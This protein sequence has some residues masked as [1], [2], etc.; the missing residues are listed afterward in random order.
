VVDGELGAPAETSAC[1]D[2]AQVVAELVEPAEIV[3]IVEPA[4]P[5]VA[6]GTANDLRAW[7]Q[8]DRRTVVAELMREHGDVVF[9]FCL[10]L[11]RVRALA[12]DLLQQVFLQA[13]RDLDQF[14][15]RSSPRA[16]LIGIAS[17]RCLDALRAQQRRST[18]IDDDQ[19]IFALEDRAPGPDERVDRMRLS[20][21][22]E[23]CLQR[24]SA[25]LRATVLLRFQTGAT[26]EELAVSLAATADTLQMRVARALPILRRCLEQKGWTGD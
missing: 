5:E 6:A 9:G 13:Y 23:G 20:A 4:V 7:S 12:D 17:H 1:P 21:A 26:Y 22:L 24:L 15:G 25:A 8:R 19:A 10:R 14:E 3:E 16:W 11:V 18:V 2:G